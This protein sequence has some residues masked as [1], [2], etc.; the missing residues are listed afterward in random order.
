M[1][2]IAGDTNPPELRSVTT[3]VRQLV[4]VI[5]GSV[6]IVL[7]GAMQVRLG[8]FTMAT[9]VFS[10]IGLFSALALLPA[11][12]HVTSEMDDLD[13]LMEQR[14]NELVAEHAL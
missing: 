8:N 7:V 4:G 3:S 12:R 6:G 9:I 1:D 11:R 10:A 13:A 5:T 2:A 14:A